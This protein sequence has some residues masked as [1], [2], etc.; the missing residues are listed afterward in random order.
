MA[1]RSL[2]GRDEQFFGKLLITAGCFYETVALWSPLPTITSMNHKGWYH[3]KF[4]L[5]AILWLL[6]WVHHFV[7][8][9]R[10]RHF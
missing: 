5:L 2:W 4:R 9:F 8:F 6:V 3:P 10:K 1:D 7:P